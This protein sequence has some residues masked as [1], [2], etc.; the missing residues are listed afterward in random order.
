LDAVEWKRLLVFTLRYHYTPSL[1]SPKRIF[2]ICAAVNRSAHARLEKLKELA[3][4]WQNPLTGDKDGVSE[5]IAVVGYTRRFF[6]V[7]CGPH[8]PKTP[9]R[10]TES[11]KIGRVSLSG[12]GVPV[13]ARQNMDDDW[14]S[15]WL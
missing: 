15:D 8:A 12:N 10:A 5:P 1:L 11:L 9:N 13:I 3:R 4:N 6:W 2:Q 7:G 14:Y